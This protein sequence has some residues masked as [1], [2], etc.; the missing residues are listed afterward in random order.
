MYVISSLSLLTIMSLSDCRQT[1][2]IAIAR[3]ASKYAVE[4]LML[5]LKTK[6]K[7]LLIIRQ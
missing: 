1:G 5:P 6:N 7:K 2:V 4:A 3:V